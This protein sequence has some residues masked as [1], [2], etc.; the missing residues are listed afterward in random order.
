MAGVVPRLS[1]AW[2]FGPR[3]RTVLAGAWRHEEA[4]VA[5]SSI[6]GLRRAADRADCHGTL[7]LSVGDNL[8]DILEFDKGRSSSRGLNTLCRQSCALQTI[9]GIRWRRRHV[10][11]H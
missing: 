6:L 7:L 4:I 8:T 10:G 2:A 1:D 11:T 5:R 3:W 9:S